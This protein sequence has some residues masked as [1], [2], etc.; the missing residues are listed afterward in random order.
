MD[1]AG[2]ITLVFLEKIRFDFDDKDNGRGDIGQDGQE[3][4]PAEAAA[5]E[6]EE[7]QRED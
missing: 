7:N 5:R 1:Q 4:Q 3:P 6:Q 2:D